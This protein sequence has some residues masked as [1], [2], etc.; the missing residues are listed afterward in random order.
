MCPRSRTY[1]TRTYLITGG[2]GFVGFHLAWRL[3]DAG[4]TVHIIDDL[5]ATTDRRVAELGSHPLCVIHKADARDPK[6]WS[7]VGSRDVDRVYSLACHATPRLVEAEPA[8]VLSTIVEGTKNALAF[9]K[10]HN[11]RVL[12]TSSSE[13]YGDP[14]Q[15]PQSEDYEGRV[16]LYCCARVCYQAAKRLG[17][18]MCWLARDKQAV[19]A[20][21]VRLFNV[22]GPGGMTDGRMIPSFVANALAGKK[23]ELYGGGMQ[24]R[25]CCYVDDTVAGIRKVMDMPQWPGDP[26]NIGNPDERTVR[27]IAEVCYRAAGKDP[28][29][30]LAKGPAQQ[31]DPARRCP[32]IRRM[33]ELTGWTP[34]V[35]LEEGIARVVDAAWNDYPRWEPWMREARRGADPRP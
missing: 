5:S 24:T 21:V 35:T 16:N 29:R 10:E 20:R 3:L 27:E 17:E 12:F 4:H 13:V 25:S 34:L 11:A 22:Y 31:H 19:D 28:N 23:S 9:A 33:N 6:A 18:S 32:D 7:F 14:E 8:K 15:C 26:V 30:M 2:A 1:N